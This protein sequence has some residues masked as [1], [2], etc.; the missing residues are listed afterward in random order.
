ME[1]FSDLAFFTVV[2]KFGNLR[3]AAQQMGVTPPAVSKRLA[4][5]E[6]RLGV[7]LMQRTTRR[8]GLTPEGETYLV[9]GAKVLADLEAL[10]RTVAGSRAV[11]KGVMRVA[12]TLGFG[13]KHVAPALSA[14]ARK[15]PEVIKL[16]T[17]PTSG[18][19]YKAFLKV[20]FYSVIPEKV[21]FIDNEQGFGKRRELAVAE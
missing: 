21:F 1:S 16:F 17:N 8:V 4:A 14:F 20:K 15:Y 9:E 3:E 19:F 6:R 10:E 12:A 11:P 18:V 2:A 13:R 5:I 7:R